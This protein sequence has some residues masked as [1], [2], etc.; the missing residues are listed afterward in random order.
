MRLRAIRLAVGRLNGD[1]AGGLLFQGRLVLCI[2]V[3]RQLR[4][5]NLL[6]V[7]RRSWNLINLNLERLL[8]LVALGLLLQVEHRRRLWLLQTKLQ[9]LVV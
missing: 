3:V 2:L 1:V 5:V 9:L 8:A 7:G 6:A 4:R